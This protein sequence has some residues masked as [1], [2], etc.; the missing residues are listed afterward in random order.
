ME[1]DRVS[2][3]L[4]LVLGL[5]LAAIVIAGAIVLAP[6]G[7]PAGAAGL[8]PVAS[9]TRLAPTATPPPSPATPTATAT[10]D[11]PTQPDR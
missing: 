11:R 4:G 3:L 10:A 1:I 2:F 8:T 5:A 9:A 7:Q 6:R